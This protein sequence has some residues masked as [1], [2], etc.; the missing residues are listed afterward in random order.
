[1]C[2]QIS[3]DRP[4]GL[5]AQRRRAIPLPGSGFSRNGLACGLGAI[6]AARNEALRHKQAHSGKNR[7]RQGDGPSPLRVK[8]A[9][10]IPARFVC[11][12]W[13]DVKLPVEPTLKLKL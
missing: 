10:P 8:P 5:D 13:L 7:C 3:P 12:N 11:T 1:L 2:R 6:S 4:G 9:R